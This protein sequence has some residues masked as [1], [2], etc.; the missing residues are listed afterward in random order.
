MTQTPRQSPGASSTH[1]E[2]RGSSTS[3]RRWRRGASTGGATGSESVPSS[4]FTDVSHISGE[5]LH[6]GN[7]GNGERNARSHQ[8]GEVAAGTPEGFVQEMAMEAGVHQGPGDG[9]ATSIVARTHGRVLD[10]AGQ[11]ELVQRRRE[12]GGGRLL[13]YNVPAPTLAGNSVLVAVE[14]NTEREILTVVSGCVNRIAE[15]G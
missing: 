14:V 3:S 15:H 2:S 9:A 6:S 12:G 10:E 11:G 13:R 5:A 4:L 7:E 1:G 8:H